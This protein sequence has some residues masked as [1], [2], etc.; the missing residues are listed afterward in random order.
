[1]RKFDWAIYMLVIGGAL[2][3][4]PERPSFEAASIK[5]SQAAIG[6]SSWNS[7]PGSIAIQGQTLKGLIVIAFQL[8]DDQVSGGPKWLDADRFDINARAAGPAQDA[9][10]LPMLQT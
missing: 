10:L 7:H 6:S 8:K 5:P 4:P 2:A 3:Q 9:E 1:M